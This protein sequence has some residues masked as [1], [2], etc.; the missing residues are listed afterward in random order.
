MDTVWNSQ[1]DRKSTR[2]MPSC[3]DENEYPTQEMDRCRISDDNRSCSEE[4]LLPSQPLQ[5]GVIGSGYGS[6]YVE[7]ETSDK[8]D[9]PGLDQGFRCQENNQSVGIQHDNPGLWVKIVKHT[10]CQP[11]RQSNISRTPASTIGFNKVNLQMNRT[12]TARI[13]KQAINTVGH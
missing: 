3:I 4:S 10:S 5:P 8:P 13:G 2:S 6:Q 1:V 7:Y 11:L 9:P 12:S